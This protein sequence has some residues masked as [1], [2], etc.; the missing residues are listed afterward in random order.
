MKSH[1]NVFAIDI[2]YGNTKSAFRNG[3]D[4]ATQMFPS[5]AP[6]AEEAALSDAGNGL[7][8]KRNVKWIEVNGTSYEVGP[9]VPLASAYGSTGRTL[10]E[11]FCTTDNYAALLGG[12]FQYA[13]VSSVDRLVLGLPVHTFKKYAA[14]LRDAFTG[15]VNFGDSKVEI[16]NVMVMPQPLGALIYFSKYHREQFDQV[17]AH[18]VVDVG[19]FTTDWVV[20]NGLTLDERRSGGA[21]GG[22]SQVYQR[23]AKLLATNEKETPADIERIDKSLRDNA[24]LWYGGRNIPLTP[25]LQKSQA[26]ISATVKEM[27]NKVGRTNDLRSIILTG[28]GA[29]LYEPTVQTAFPRVQIEVLEAPCFANVKGFFAAGEA[30]LRREQRAQSAAA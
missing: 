7:F 30:T 11:D 3:S 9:G 28:G 16:A 21:P 27:Q 23:I 15:K 29:A 1:A 22:A 19:Y 10:S 6:L 26:L 8:E 24:P 12:S 2:G 18:L 14:S 25:Y 20:A 4:V 17:N 5:L 13:N